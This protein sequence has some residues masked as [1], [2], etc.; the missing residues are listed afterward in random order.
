MKK[1]SVIM[2]IYNCA[3]TLSEA[4]DSILNQTF[5]NWELILC[6]DG[7]SDDT[8]KIAENYALMNP[9]KIRLIKHEKNQGLATAL[10]SCLREVTG[11]YVARMDGDDRSM[12]ERFAMQVQFLETHSDVQLVGTAMLRFNETGNIGVDKKPEHPDRYTLKKS[13][14]F[15]HATI[16]TYRYV[17]EKLNGYTV[18]EIT[19]R[20]EDHDLWF[21]FYQEGFVG[22]N[23][24]EPL[25]CVREDLNA[26]KRRTLKGRIACCKVMLNGYKLLGYPKTWYWYP[27]F[28]VL[29]AFVPS[30]FVML[31]RRFQAR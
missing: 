22:C 21:R 31:Y 25:Y 5:T 28:E 26:I 11:D 12:P 9:G 3:D 18:S 13:V 10:N 24:E 4:I 8:Y 7:S 23:L 27:Y 30:S 29:K 2:G 16:M 6:D 14:P 15:N 20:E 17:Y 19:K 1:V